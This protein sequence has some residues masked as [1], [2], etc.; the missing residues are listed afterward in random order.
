[1]LL[2]SQDVHYTPHRE[3]NVLHYKQIASNL[4][5]VQDE[6]QAVKYKYF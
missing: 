6:P 4:A 3:I 1:M 2:P 5:I